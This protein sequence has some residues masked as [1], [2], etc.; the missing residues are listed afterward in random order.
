MDTNHLFLK[1]LEPFKQLSAVELTN[2]T[3]VAREKHYDK[4][5]TIFHEGQPSEYVWLVKTGRVHTVRVHSNG[6]VSTSCV[7]AP[8]EMFC[9]LPTLDQKSYPAD[10]VA[11]AKTAVIRIPANVF[12]DSMTRSQEFNKETLCLFCD[13]L[14]QVEFKGCMVYEPAEERFAQALL[15]LAKKFGPT[16][17]LT[18]QELAELTGTAPETAI[19]VLSRFGKEGFVRSTRGKI[20]IL[21]TDKLSELL[22]HI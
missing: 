13:R 6:K 18:R 12:R 22:N 8:G 2:L 5:E 7:M 16:I 17:P 21:R 3:Q 19:R 11:A 1:D 14:R 10:A 4:G 9:C 15:A 20:T